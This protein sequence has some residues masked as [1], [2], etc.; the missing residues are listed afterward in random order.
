[1]PLEKAIN[2]HFVLERDEFGKASRFVLRT[3]PAKVRWAGYV[4]TGLLFALMLTGAAFRPGGKL[5]PVSLVIL[6]LVWLMA[7][8]AQIAHRAGTE[9]R[10][11]PMAGREI[12]YEF[13]ETGFRCGLPN[14]ESRLNWPA[15][16]SFIETDA[17]FVVVE[18]GVLYYTVPK[19]T[20]AAD[21][22]H[23]LR[24]LLV[25]KVPNRT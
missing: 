22:C 25:E 15:I 24:R 3:L 18:S 14:S 12:R 1:M 17:L 9:L 19:R 10:F 7:L 6:V 5:Q 8:A 21:D 23:A 13:D 2:T 20:L 16:S 11:A 4:Q